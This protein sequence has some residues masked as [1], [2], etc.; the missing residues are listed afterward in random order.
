MANELLE[1][2]YMEEMAVYATHLTTLKGPKTDQN[3]DNNKLSD[4]SWFIKQFTYYILFITQRTISDS[5]PIKMVI[6]TFLIWRVVSDPD[7]TVWRVISRWDTT[8]QAVISGSDT[9]LQQLYLSFAFFQIPHLQSVSSLD[10][11]PCTQISILVYLIWCCC[12]NKIS[13][14]PLVDLSPGSLRYTH[15]RPEYHSQSGQNT[16]F[17]WV[18]TCRLYLRV[19]K[20]AKNGPKMRVLDLPQH[21][22]IN[23]L[24]TNKNTV[25]IILTNQKTVVLELTNQNSPA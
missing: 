7:I 6:Y 24:L 15:G 4:T 3:S 1:Y 8:L 10:T 11:T 21:T 22:T 19:E 25:F 2:S 14:R 17:S 20:W 16:R 12:V 9:T 13:H 5:T 23:K 18:H